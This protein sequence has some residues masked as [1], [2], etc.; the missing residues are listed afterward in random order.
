MCAM[1]IKIQ[2]AGIYRINLDGTGRPPFIMPMAF[3]I[4]S[5]FDWHPTTKELWFTDNGRDNDGR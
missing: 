5:D 2:Y 3:E 1:R 4:R